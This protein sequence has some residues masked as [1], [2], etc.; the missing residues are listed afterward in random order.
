[1]KNLEN[2]GIR[3]EG[4]EARRVVGFAIEFDEVRGAVA[5]RELHEAQP[6]AMRL[7]PERLGIDRDAARERQ[8]GRQISIVQLDFG[9]SHL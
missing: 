8:P 3:Q 2:L 5:A 6:V 7:E 4:F 1:M 9:C